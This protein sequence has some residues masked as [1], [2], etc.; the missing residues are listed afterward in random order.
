MFGASEWQSY[1]F[2]WSFAISSGN[3]TNSFQ[4]VKIVE[5]IVS[6]NNVTKL[7][8]DG[9]KW[10]TKYLRWTKI[11][12]NQSLF[13]WN[14]RRYAAY[15]IHTKENKK[16]NNHFE[17]TRR[18][19]FWSA[20]LLIFACVFF[21]DFI[22]V[23]TLNLCSILTMGI[24]YTR[25]CFFLPRQNHSFTDSVNSIS[26]TNKEKNRNKNEQWRDGAKSAQNANPSYSILLKIVSVVL[27]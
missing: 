14:F 21:C 19:F 17:M 23:L 24:N 5:S 26:G 2:L 27:H 7:Q 8:C 10:T 18:W 22:D 9:V 15:L 4:N 6:I 16:N 11:H 3:I 20:L 25:T 1:S 13:Q 12:Q